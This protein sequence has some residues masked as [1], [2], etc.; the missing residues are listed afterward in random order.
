MFTDFS[1]AFDSIHR[2]KMEQI[3]LAHGLLRETVTAMIYGNTKVKVR[4][5]DEDIDFF[6]IVSGVLQGD[7]S[8]TSVYNLPKLRTSNVH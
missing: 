7:I 8:S 1:K 5:P 2:E 4:S 6:D 3:L